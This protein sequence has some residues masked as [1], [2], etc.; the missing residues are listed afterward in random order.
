MFLPEFLNQVTELA[1]KFFILDPEDPFKTT[2][3][4]VAMCGVLFTVITTLLTKTYPW[5]R[6]KLEGRSVSNRVGA[7]LF[8]A[9][10][11]ERTLRYY[12]P[13]FCQALDPAGGEESRLVHNVQSPLFNTLDRT[14]SP[15]SNERYHILLADSGMG[16]TSALINYYA[17]HLRRWRRK[18]H[19]AIIPL[20]IPDADSRIKAIENKP[21]TVLFLDALDEDTKA[22]N[23]HKERLE[24]LLQSTHDFLHVLITCRTQFF[25]RDEEIPKE[26][27]VLKV[28]ARRAGERAEYV[29]YKIYL[30]PFTDEQVAKYLKRRYPIWQWKHRQHAFRMVRKIPHL[31]ARPMLLAHVDDLVSANHEVR[32]S[33]E[34][35]EEMVE[36][37]LTREEG[38]IENKDDLRHFSERLAVNLYLGR[39]GRMSERISTAEL[40]KL[41]RE[42]NIP[43]DNWKLSGRSLLNRDAEGNFKFAHRSIM[44]YLFIKRL[45]D[46]ESKCLDA[47]WTD[48]MKTFFWEMVVAHRERT[49][50]A[51]FADRSHLIGLTPFRQIMKCFPDVK[52]TGGS[53][54]PDFVGE[55]S[56]S[57]RAELA[58][59][60]LEAYMSSGG[61]EST[62]VLYKV[63]GAELLP[64]NDERYDIYLTL[65]IRPQLRT[66]K[67]QPSDPDMLG[68]V[69]ILAR[70]KQAL[71]VEETGKR[72]F[73]IRDVLL[74]RLDDQPAL[75]Y[76][77]L[78]GDEARRLT[79]KLLIICWDVPRNYTAS[80]RVIGELLIRAA[81]PFLNF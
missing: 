30:S 27:G 28:G 40:S 61:K 23:D 41:A 65:M 54:F 5:I 76:L 6:A 75:A 79:A 70:R 42:W 19:I 53:M 29:F 64:T 50:H 16:K 20:G 72:K 48:Q 78:E 46:G 26:T 21:E 37:W 77:V 11:V 43:L 38:F 52:D 69:P 2:A 58:L 3:K 13:P 12:V 33:F 10:N 62:V 51:I 15:S 36:A 39:E 57:V 60:T 22:I 63:T 17:R 32:Y 71:I 1:N 74:G 45:M 68:K 56:E 73:F 25:L 55:L 80:P 35:Y 9:S 24:T 67:E 18:Y 81:S 59:T 4:V 47:K 8:T 66:T 49:G 44:E 7:K 34:L 31:T 14:L